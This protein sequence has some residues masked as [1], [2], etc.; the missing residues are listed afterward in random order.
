M[1]VM[2]WLNGLLAIVRNPL[3]IISDLTP[4]LGIL[5]MLSFL[6][7]E[8]LVGFGVVGGLTMIFVHNGLGL[9]SDATFYR[10]ELKLQDMVVASPVKPWAY[11]F[12]LAISGLLFSLPGVLTFTALIFGLGL[13]VL[14]PVQMIGSALML[15]ASSTSIGFTVSTLFRDMR[16]V[17]PTSSILIYSI[18]ILPPVYY[19]YYLLPEWAQIPVLLVPTASGALLIQDSMGLVSP[20]PLHKTISI[21]AL[22]LSLLVSSVIAAKKSRWRQP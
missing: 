18:S 22:T 11:M 5:V 15:W 21:L 10:L 19:P 6:G 13:R 2:A 1:L 4:P 16:E 8:E 9:L 12:G 14:N 17:W 7:R 20:S 3:W